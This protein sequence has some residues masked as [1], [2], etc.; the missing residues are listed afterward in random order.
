MCSLQLCRFPCCN[1]GTQTTFHLCTCSSQPVPSLNPHHPHTNLQDFLD[2]KVWLC[3]GQLLSRHWPAVRCVRS[4]LLNR[5]LSTLKVVPMPF[6]AGKRSQAAGQPE[7]LAHALHP[8]I[9]QP[10]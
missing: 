8:A 1:K 10:R 4:C 9:A 5:S 7:R 6:T 3:W 2:S